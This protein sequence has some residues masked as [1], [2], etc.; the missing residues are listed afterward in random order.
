M[1]KILA[2]LLTVIMVFGLVAC[3]DKK[4]D[5]A[6]DTDKAEEVEQDADEKDAETPAEGSGKVYYLN[7]KPEQDQQWQELAEVYTQ[8]TGVPVRVV[9]AA[10]GEYE[11]TLMAEMGKS[12]APTL[13]QVNGPVGL[14]NWEAQC[15]DLADSDVVSE[16]TS[17][18]FALKGESG[19]T[20]GVAYV[21]ESYGIITNTTLLEE[22]GYSVDDIQS[23]ADLKEVA[24]DITARKDELGFSAFSSAGMD[25]SSDW[26][27]KT[28]L[29]NMPIYFEY[30][31]DGI[32]DTAAIKGTFL[33]NYRNI[34]DL[35]VNNSTADPAELSAKTGDDS[36][37]EFLAKEAVFF[38]NGSWEYSNL[39]GED[40]FKA[41]ELT[42][43]PIYIGEGDEANQGLCTG[44]EN[45]WCVNKDAEQE[46][47]DATLAFMNWCVTSDVGVKAMSGGEGAMP[48]GDPG[49]GF[50]IPFKKALESENV[51]VKVDADMTA[52]GK[53]P[54][55]WTFSTMPSEEW[56]NGVG[57][58]LTAYAADQT[59]DN[60]QAVV[61]AFVDGWATEYELSN[62]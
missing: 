42:M 49:M 26:R 39:V 61:T 4:D 43:I 25:G 24:E 56:K 3:G 34:W 59:D 28:H 51:F 38:Q 9:T 33:D 15:Y 21:V 41:D 62:P 13:F 58:A 5:Q 20:S 31:A 47:I 29:A 46:D 30:Q 6:K 11:T 54:V 53:T 52:A 23:F 17:D 16:L 45:F 32:Q 40:L 44:T 10:S 60:W 1:K 50:V 8:E 37:N 48:S 19:E 18:A 2:I 55:A 35:Y 36:R 57:S 7:F 27:F 22:A 14:K 12:D